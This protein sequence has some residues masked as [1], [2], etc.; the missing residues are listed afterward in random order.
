MSDV[1]D[2]CSS[3]KDYRIAKATG[4]Y[5]YYHPIQASHAATEVEL[6]G[7]RVIMAGSNNYLGLAQDPRVKE[8]AINA[9]KRF[10]TTCSGSRLLNGTLSLHEELESRLSK[11]LK[12]EAALV[13]S[14]GFQTN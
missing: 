5:P 11:F 8:A 6:D 12:R 10:G 9:T 1:F 14:T 2:K 4:L 13:V 7:R 3:W